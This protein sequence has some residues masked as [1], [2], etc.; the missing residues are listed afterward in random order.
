MPDWNQVGSQHSKMSIRPRC[1]PFELGFLMQLGCLSVCRFMIKALICTLVK[2]FE[3]QTCSDHEI[4]AYH[5][6]EASSLVRIV[7]LAEHAHVWGPLPNH[8]GPQ[9]VPT[10][11]QHKPRRLETVCLQD[12]R[13]LQ[14]CLWQGASW[15]IWGSQYAFRAQRPKR[16]QLLESSWIILNEWAEIRISAMLVSCEQSRFINSSVLQWCM[17]WL[18][19]Q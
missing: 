9:E 6:I 3:H 15:M 10:I 2:L 16:L 11:S 17:R 19:L 13:F 1:K 7:Y 4:E 14:L 5:E 18:G 8:M 12:F